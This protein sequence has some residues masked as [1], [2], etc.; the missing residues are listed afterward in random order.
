MF[1]LLPTYPQYEEWK[2][3]LIFPFFSGPTLLFHAWNV[4]LSC[5]ITLVIVMEQEKRKKN[6]RGTKEYARM[7]NE[8]RKKC[9]LCHV[10][11]NIDILFLYYFISTLI[12][13]STMMALQFLSSY[14]TQAS[15]W[16]SSLIASITAVYI[17]KYYD[18]GDDHHHYDLFY[19]GSQ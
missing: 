7:W 6:K 13:P 11:S 19:R 14:H 2:I 15:A 17:L 18:D 8:K 5:W 1:N 4:M 16:G 10:K 3:L 12:K 9:V